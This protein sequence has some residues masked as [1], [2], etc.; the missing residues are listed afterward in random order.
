MINQEMVAR[1]ETRLRRARALLKDT[2]TA[3][4]KLGVEAILRGWM[5]SSP[6]RCP[7]YLPSSTT[8]RCPSELISAS[9]GTVS[10]SRRHATPANSSHG[11]F[12]I[13]V[14]S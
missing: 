1:P 13:A 2:R 7:Y 6:L 12:P 10:P 9:Y 14:T 4:K 3:D 11:R 5:S 8:L